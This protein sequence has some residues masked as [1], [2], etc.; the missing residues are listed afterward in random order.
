MMNY[1]GQEPAVKLEGRVVTASSTDT[2]NT[3]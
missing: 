3:N 1:D 2:T